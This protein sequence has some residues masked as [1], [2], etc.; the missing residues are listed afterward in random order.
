[1]TRALTYPIYR[2]ALINYSRSLPYARYA[3]QAF[4]LGK[5]AYKVARAGYRSYR[6]R[7]RVTAPTKRYVKRAIRRSKGPAHRADSDD[8]AAKSSGALGWFQLGE[9]IGQGVGINQRLGQSICIRGF[10]VRWNITNESTAE[11]K[12]IRMYLLKIRDSDPVE[13]EFFKGIDEAAGED[14]TNA[15]DP[16]KVRRPLNRKRF[17]I[18]WQKRMKIPGDFGDAKSMGSFQRLGGKLFKMREKRLTFERATTSVEGP[19]D[20]RP[21]YVFAYHIERPYTGISD[22]DCKMDLKFT[23][24]FCPE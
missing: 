9:D 1:M 14:F 5:M 16:D 19:K 4:K 11:H 7:K 20:I 22:Q 8:L 17:L 23:T 15:T 13:Q 24:Y 6:K 10:H 2:G 21:R 12:W 18:M 3:P